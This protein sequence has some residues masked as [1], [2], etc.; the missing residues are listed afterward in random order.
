MK[1]GNIFYKGQRFSIHT[2]TEYESGWPYIY[3]GHYTIVHDGEFD[4][5]KFW[6]GEHSR[7]IKCLRHD[8][9]Y[10]V[11]DKLYVF[12]KDMLQK[13]LEDGN[14]HIKKSSEEDF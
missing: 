4:G 1:T 7:I 6:T 13:L 5:E 8:A 14:L 2:K 9:R 11:E 12:G 3:K 10:T